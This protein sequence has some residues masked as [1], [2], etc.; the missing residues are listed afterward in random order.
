MKTIDKISEATELER[1]CR[2]RFQHLTN[3]QL[4]ARIN[5]LPDFGWDDEGVELQRRHRVSNGAFDYEMRGNTIVILKDE[6][7]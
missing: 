3:E 7:Q 5:I 2:K 1:F 4:V 6:K